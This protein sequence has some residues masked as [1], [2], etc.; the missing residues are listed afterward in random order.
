LARR[1]PA[2]ARRSGEETLPEDQLLLGLE[3]AEQIEATGEEEKE[4]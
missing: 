1:F 3:E 2:F 4:R